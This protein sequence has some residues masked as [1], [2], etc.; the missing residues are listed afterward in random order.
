[1]PFFEFFND[2][3][4]ADVQHAR[5]IANPAGIHR[6]I[7]DLLL[8]P[9]GLPSISILQEKRASTLWTR[10]T[11][12]ALLPFR[13]G[14]MANNICTLAVG[15]VQDL[16]YHG[17][18]LSQGG[19]VPLSIGKSNAFSTARVRPH[20]A[21]QPPS[22]WCARSGRAHIPPRPREPAPAAPVREASHWPALSAAGRP[23][24]RAAGHG[25]DGGLGTGSLR[26]WGCSEGLLGGRLQT[27]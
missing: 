11:P 27:R 16:R 3:G 19:C 10:A 21:P 25:Q 18:S 15:A 5:S 24:A 14:A 4:R 23:Q 6:H 22:R 2:C 13:R 8:D 26:G 20:R 1:V 17:G 12:I 9:R 7:D